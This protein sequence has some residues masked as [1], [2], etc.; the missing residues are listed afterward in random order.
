GLKTNPSNHENALWLCGDYALYCGISA[1]PNY[2]YYF[3]IEYDV[4][5]TR[6]NPFLLEALI[7]RLQSL[8]GQALDLIC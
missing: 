2:D 7:N 1:Q 6:E 8:D 4:H 5:F 3:M